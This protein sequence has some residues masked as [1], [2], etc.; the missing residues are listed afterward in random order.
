M[1]HANN[2]PS[3]SSENSYRPRHARGAVAG[4]RDG[5]ASP[6]NAAPQSGTAAGVAAGGSTGKTATASRT[7]IGRSTRMMSA[8]VILSRVTGFLRTWAQAL[9]VGATIVS[10]CYTLSNNLLTQ[11]YGLVA[12]GLI[13]TGF[14]PVYV[15][16]RKRG[17]QEGGNDYVSNLL[18]IVGL[19]LAVIVALSIIFAPQLVWLQSFNATSEFDADLAVWFFRIFAVEFLLYPLSGIFTG[20]NNA[21]REYF[22]SNFAPTL[23]NVI[24]AASFG[25]YTFLVP[26]NQE[27]GL[28]VLAVGNVLGVVFQVG[29]QIVPALRRGLRLRFKVDLHDPRLKDTLSIGVPM[30]AVTITTFITSSV[31]TSY[32][33]SITA[34][35][36]SIM[37]YAQVWYALPYSVFSTPLSTALYTELTESYA[38]GDLD[39]FRR[40][41]AEGTNSISFYLIPCTLL[42]I[43]FSIPLSCV[44]AGSMTSDDILLTANYLSWCAPTLTFWGLA[45][46]LQK[47]SSSMGRMS[48]FAVAAVLGSVGQALICVVF[49]PLFGL[50]A[51]AL[52][53]LVYQGTLVIVTFVVMRRRLGRIGLRG[54]AIG[55]GQAL[56]GGVV[57]A[58]VGGALLWLIGGFN[59]SMGA[60]RAVI[61]CVAAGVPALVAVVAAGTLLGNP[62][63]VELV[64]S[65]KRT[66]GRIFGK[67]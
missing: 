61:D 24:V 19:A 6:E 41:L 12:G 59:P 14:M 33:L 18:S 42:L 8:L 53:S 40:D 47:A 67:R 64:G 44:I 38:T 66:V 58:V 32:A 23:N 28:I 48:Y 5:H 4:A 36:S 20:I 63:A 65:M 1:K 15:Q 60:A 10:S 30:L 56:L 3:P 49:T 7:D 37:Y 27:L 54:I 31:Q 46:Y 35:A 45:G 29:V 9:A 22:W 50:P 57:G 51:V 16:A 17:G 11:L 25:A 2:S 13:V 62:T 43:V 39:A 21:D 26:V 55:Q 52:S 34:A